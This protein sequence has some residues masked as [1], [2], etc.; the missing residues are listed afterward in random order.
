VSTTWG[1]SLVTQLS[2]FFQP[3][4]CW[5]IEIDQLVDCDWLDFRILSE[6]PDP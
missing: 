5:V 4:Y 2:V 3:T 6:P 1:L